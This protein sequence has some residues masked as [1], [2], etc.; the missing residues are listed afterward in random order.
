MVM[1]VGGKD[2]KANSPQHPFYMVIVGGNGE[3]GE[4]PASEI[5]GILRNSS[6]RT[7]EL[8]YKL[9]TQR[10]DGGAGYDYVDIKTGTEE[11]IPVDGGIITIRNMSMDETIYYAP[12]PGKQDRGIPLLPRNASRM[13]IIDD[14]LYIYAKADTRV[15]YTFLEVT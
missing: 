7:M 2:Q 12:E 3:V 1:P 10:P 11:F 5:M 15:H 9:V 6:V 8:P 4:D 14:N 13:L